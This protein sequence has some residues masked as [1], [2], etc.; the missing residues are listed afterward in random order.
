LRT[1]RGYLLGKARSP[2]FGDPTKSPVLIRRFVQ[3]HCKFEPSLDSM[4]VKSA[5]DCVV[6]RDS[7]GQL[8]SIGPPGNYVFSCGIVTYLYDIK[9]GQIQKRPFHPATDHR[10]APPPRRGFKFKETLAIIAGGAEGYSVKSTGGFLIDSADAVKDTSDSLQMIIYTCLGAISGLVFG[11]WLGYEGKP[12]CGDPLFQ[13]LLND[14]VFLERRSRYTR[15][16]HGGRPEIP[17]VGT[18][19][20][21]R[22]NSCYDRWPYTS[23]RHPED[24]VG[25]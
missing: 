24:E 22:R 12:K 6:R 19:A 5:Y 11:F 2:E 9:T 20:Q 7:K 10:Y 3:E 23:G 17:M 8:Q 18:L 25:S 13:Q 4:A 21:P 1:V 15:R 14:P 16:F